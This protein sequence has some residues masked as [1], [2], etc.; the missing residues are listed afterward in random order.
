MLSRA[1]FSLLVAFVIVCIA[2]DALGQAWVEWKQ[3]LWGQIG[4]AIREKLTLS[5][6]RTFSSAPR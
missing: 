5:L 1:R 6:R 4:M 3:F 2:L